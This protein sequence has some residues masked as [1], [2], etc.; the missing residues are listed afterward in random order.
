MIQTYDA[1]V[2]VT[3]KDF[4]RVR[5]NNERIIRNLPVRKVIFVGS[6]ELGELVRDYKQSDY[7]SRVGFVNEDDLILF[8]EVYS[9]M[10]SAMADI[11]QG[12][13]LPRGLVGWYYQQF[14][15]MKYAAVCKDEYYMTWD[16]D[17]VPCKIF[18]MFDECGKP[19]F[20]MK[21]EYHEEYFI[22]MGK[23]L[24]GLGK[25]NDKSFISEH[26]LFNCGYMK[27]M[28][29]KIEERDDIKG[30]SFWEKILNAIRLEHIQ[31]NS[32]S[33]F[34]TYGTYMSV[35]HPDVYAFRNWHSFRYGGYYF[36]PERMTDRDYEWLSKDFYTISLKKS[37]TVRFADFVFIPKPE[38][39]SYYP[40]LVVEL[41]WNKSADTALQQIEDRFYPD[42]VRS[43]TG[44]ILLVGINYDTHTKE[45]TC[46]IKKY[47]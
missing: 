18:S 27:E 32:F 6:S 33:E 17:T 44:S 41:K 38:Y 20:D 12:R 40:A 47:I 24:P 23:I 22:T 39:I 3:P 42:S 7:G 34:E 43:Y 30:K 28:I 9:C 37:Y 15:K 36:H 35:N 14:L 10:E 21:C 29:E 5:E 19:Y 16:G 46:L 25:V 2:V 13:E 4:K 26:M 45:H 11:L 8:S 1:I 31:E